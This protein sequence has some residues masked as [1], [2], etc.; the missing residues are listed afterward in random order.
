[1]RLIGR[2][3]LHSLQNQSTQVQ[4]WLLTWVA[5]VMGAHW[6]CPA[7]V[8]RQFPNA[9]EGG[10]NLFVFPVYSCSCS[11]GLLVAFPQEIALISTLI[12]AEKVH[13]S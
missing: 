5:E 3:K 12:S 6:K 10:T 7:D 9:S 1:M 11:I 2:K 4:R 13:G 8:I